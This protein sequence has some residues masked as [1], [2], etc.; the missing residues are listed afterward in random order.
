MPSK[1]SGWLGLAISVGSPIIG[2]IQIWQGKTPRR[3]HRRTRVT[4]VGP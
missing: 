2:I 4:H 1:P 3:R